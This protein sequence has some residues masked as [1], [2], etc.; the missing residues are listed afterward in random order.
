[1]GIGIITSVHKPE[2][3]RTVLGDSYVNMTLE[4]IEK[5]DPMAV[6]KQRY[7]AY[8]FMYITINNIRVAFFTFVFGILFGFGTLISLLRNGIMLGT[9]QYFFIERNLFKESFLTIWQHGTLEISSIVIA[10]AA[11]F[12]IGRGLLIPGTFTRFQSLKITARRGVKV[13][14]GL[15]PVFI[16]AAFIEAFFTRYTDIPDAIRLLTILFSLGFILIYFV[17]YPRKVAKRHPEKLEIDDKINQPDNK[18]PNLKT[19]LDNELLFGG[20][21]TSL[22]LLLPKLTRIILIGSLAFGAFLSIGRPYFFS[23]FNG[24]LF[25]Q[26]AT[27]GFILNYKLNPNVYFLHTIFIGLIVYS[28]ICFYDQLIKKR[29]DIPY[30]KPRYFAIAINSFITSAIL[31]A[32]F[33]LSAGWG[34]FLI[35]TI[36]PFLFVNLQVC[37]TE[38]KFIFSGI[39][40]TFQLLGSSF[41]SFL[42]LNLK[43]LFI[44]GLL[45]LLLSPRFYKSLLQIVKWNLWL[46]DNYVD[47]VLNMIVLFIF[48]LSISFTLILLLISNALLYFSMIEQSTAYFLRQKINKIGITKTLR[49]YELEN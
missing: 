32:L 1:M 2:F 35:I 11:G 9:F 12:T 15:I 36:V 37:T 16:F 20:T 39:G 7:E 47:I 41:G 49:G 21:L 30:V 8:F 19:I 14:L 29:T 40:K 46:E 24:T 5:N 28:G 18:F 26:R 3:A 22:K 31:N 33:F 42:L 43:F 48:Y 45:L 44:G 17:L 27:Y 25:E 10:G 4:N 38:N 6:Y 34:L 13:M 23:L